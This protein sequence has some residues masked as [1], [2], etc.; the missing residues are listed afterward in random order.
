M[1]EST[2]CQLLDLQVSGLQGF[3][4]PQL[5]ARPG[6]H[7][8]CSTL[9]VEERTSSRIDTD[10]KSGDKKIAVVADHS[11]LKSPVNLN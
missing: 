10:D 1:V 5:V 3:V 11:K 4:N 2:D 8:S 6:L 9:I 7:G